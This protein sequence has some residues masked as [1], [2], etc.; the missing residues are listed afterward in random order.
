MRLLVMGLLV[1]MQFAL[2]LISPTPPVFFFAAV[3][4]A[5]FF[6]TLATS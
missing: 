1:A 6:F 2:V 3:T 5:A 4:V